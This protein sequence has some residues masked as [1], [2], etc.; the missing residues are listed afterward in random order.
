MWVLL[1]SVCSDML[2]AGM[3]IWVNCLL[4]FYGKQICFEQ[5]QYEINDK[6]WN[7]K[8]IMCEDNFSVAIMIFFMKQEMYNR[9]TFMWVIYKFILEFKQNQ[10]TCPSL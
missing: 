1:F 5:I 8:E 2:Q 10:H 4:T 3:K 9:L 6:V 7:V